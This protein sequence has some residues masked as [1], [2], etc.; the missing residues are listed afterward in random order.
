MTTFTDHEARMLLSYLTEPADAEVGRMLELIT[1]SEFL[2][3][4]FAGRTVPGGD[5]LRSRLA[6][7]SPQEL[8]DR[9]VADAERHNIRFITPHVPEWPTAL[10]ILGA[11]RPHGLWVKGDASTLGMLNHVSETVSIVG[12]RAATSYGE[13][14][15]IEI[16]TDLVGAKVPIVSGAAYG[17]DGA[18]HRAALAAGGTTVAFLASG[19]D[20]P[21]PAGNANLLE[22]ITQ[23]GGVVSE[24][25]PGSAPT[26]WRF[27]ARNRLIAAV[28]DMTVVVEGGTRSGSINTARHALRLGRMLGAVPGPVTSAASS[29]T[30]HLL[31][32]GARVITS[33]DDV[34]ADLRGE[35][36]TDV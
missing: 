28:A 26:K 30:N 19:V 15:A 36:E 4:L 13:H 17:I 29:G 8:I 1:P 9:M 6:E 24:A 25:P 31:R 12:A 7:Q 22:R 5:R 10:D 20:R 18:A 3:E 14:V 2:V 32:Q 23:S 21:Y 34:L 35:G 11:S 16:A 33:A 27:L